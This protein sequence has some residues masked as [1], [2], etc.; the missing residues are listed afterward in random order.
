MLLGS[1]ASADQNIAVHPPHRN[2][3]RV[4]VQAIPAHL[5]HNY[6]EEQEHN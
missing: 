4:A 1:D 6:E 3:G 5:A 2:A